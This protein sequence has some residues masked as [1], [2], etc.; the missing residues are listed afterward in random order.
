M[1]NPSL[2]FL[3]NNVKNL[4]SLDKSNTYPSPLQILNLLTQ[5]SIRLSKSQIDTYGFFREAGMNIY[6]VISF[7]YLE[8]LL[9]LN[10]IDYIATVID[11]MRTPDYHVLTNPELLTRNGNISKEIRQKYL[12]VQKILVSVLEGYLDILLNDPT[13]RLEVIYDFY[14]KCAKDE[15]IKLACNAFI[16]FFSGILLAK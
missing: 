6:E 9:K 16:R 7:G 5:K 3:E 2:I 15:D 8:N 13:K 10:S 11:M 1:E 4:K 14:A 12:N